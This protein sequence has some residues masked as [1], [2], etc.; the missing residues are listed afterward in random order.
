MSWWDEML[1]L[2]AKMPLI[3][4]VLST[5]LFLF[6]FRWNI[7]GTEKTLKDSSY[8]DTGHF[9]KKLG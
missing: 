2:I 8:D 6:S 3:E 9:H 7:V 5:H 1:N 4:Q